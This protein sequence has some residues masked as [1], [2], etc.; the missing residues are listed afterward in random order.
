MSTE[1]K[2]KP[3][4]GIHYVA[5]LIALLFLTGV[6]FGLS[7]VPMGAA[8]PVVALAIAGVKVVVVATMFMHL[9]ESV[10]ATRLIG[11]VT[12]A[13]VTLLCLGVFADIGFR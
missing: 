9:R 12:I 3:E 4:R 2:D 10:F 13:F 6:S 7:Y 5:A 11:I 8:G 1:R